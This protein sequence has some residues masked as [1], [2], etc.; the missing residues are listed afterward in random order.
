MEVVLEQ[1]WVLHA[2]LSEPR[3]LVHPLPPAPSAKG[4]RRGD[5]REV[6]AVGAAALAAAVALGACTNWSW[7]HW[8][9]L[10]RSAANVATF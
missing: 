3:V 2:Y 6:T 8:R 7:T 5:D 10:N 9:L 1:I 4:T